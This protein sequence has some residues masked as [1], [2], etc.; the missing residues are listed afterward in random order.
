MQGSSDVE[1]LKSL[2]LT[3]LF[4]LYVS[5][6]LA[7]GQTL[8]ASQTLFSS[9]SDPQY[10]N[11]RRLLHQ[12]GLCQ[13][14]FI[15]ASSK[16]VMKYFEYHACL[17]ALCL[18]HNFWFLPQSLRSRSISCLLTLLFSLCTWAPRHL[19]VHWCPPSRSIRDPSPSALTECPCQ[20]HSVPGSLAVCVFAEAPTVWSIAG[21]H[22]LFL[23]CPR[24]YC[25]CRAIS[26]ITYMI[27]LF[28]CSWTIAG[29]Q[30]RSKSQIP[31]PRY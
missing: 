23:Q 29:G 2:A 17:S 20:G 15:R 21:V 6:P 19:V 4:L 10:S 25:A 27:C 22:P 14:I 12:Y 24:Q 5:H 8:Q 9:C 7:F 31:Q 18:P 26:Y 13:F 3:T 28:S 16:S 30:G 11:C 1:R